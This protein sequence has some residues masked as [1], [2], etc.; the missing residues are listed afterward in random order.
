MHLFLIRNIEYEDLLEKF[1]IA[2]VVAIL[3]IRL[4]L[5]L[6]DY[7]QLS[8]KGLHIAHML[9]GGLLMAAALLILLL[10]L[11]RYAKQLA[12]VLG[13]IGFG[14]FIDELGKFI[15]SDNNYFY[16]PTAALIYIIF[17]LIYLLSH[18]L[19]KYSRFQSEE[20]LTNSLDLLKEAIISD[21]DK[22]EKRR[23]LGYLAKVD[24]KGPIF[25]TIAKLYQRLDAIPPPPPNLVNRWFTGLKSFYF[26]LAQQKWFAKIIV[27]LF[28]LQAVV[29]FFSVIFL[30][31]GTASLVFAFNLPAELN[32]L[33][34]SDILTFLASSLAGI[35]IILGALKI[36]AS[37]LQAYEL[38]KRSLLIS[39]FLVQV[40]TFYKDQFSAFFGLMWDILILTALNFMI[41]REKS[42]LLKTNEE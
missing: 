11:N 28:L 4:F 35:F 31:F 14:V 2:A 20:Y 12:A 13:G 36:H 9:W 17:V 40:F 23:A 15:T 10:F 30:I 33:K 6:T 27:L 3:G 25:Q 22:E 26:N 19:R 41:E 18:S 8:G 39:I 29:S 32:Q 37:K 7:A 21:L 42:L 5:K 34:T 1:F 24:R 16:Q 38:F